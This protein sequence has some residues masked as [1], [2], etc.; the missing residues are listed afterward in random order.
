[1]E[2]KINEL[3]NFVDTNEDVYINLCNG[4]ITTVFEYEGKTKVSKEGNDLIISTL[5]TRVSL[6]K[7]YITRIVFKRN[8]VFIEFRA[9]IKRGAFDEY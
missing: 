4:I 2:T 7:D 6:T 3:I 9:S 1:M 5:H 8:C